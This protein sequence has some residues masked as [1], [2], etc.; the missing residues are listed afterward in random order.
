MAKPKQRKGAIATPE[1]ILFGPL[2]KYRKV[3]V[4]PNGKH[5]PTYK[6]VYS[7]TPPSK[8]D[9]AFKSAHNRQGMPTGC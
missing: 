4:V 5:S 7:H 3:E 6:T 2:P 9:V 1:D 8:K